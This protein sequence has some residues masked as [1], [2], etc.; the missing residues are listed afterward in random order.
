MT[1]KVSIAVVIY[2]LDTRVY[3]Y[4]VTQDTF[5]SSQNT[6]MPCYTTNYKTINKQNDKQSQYCKSY[7]SGSKHLDNKIRVYMYMYIVNTQEVFLVDQHLDQVQI[8]D[9]QTSRDQT[10]CH[11]DLYQMGQG[12]LFLLKMDHQ[13]QS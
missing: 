1:N 10:T 6:V 11:L 5:I 13:R 9:H 2:I 12:H 7:L 8:W 3:M 4:I